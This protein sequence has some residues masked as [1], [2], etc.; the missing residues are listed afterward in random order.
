MRFSH[1]CAV[2]IHTDTH[3][4]GHTLV[5]V[6]H[7]F[8]LFPGVDPTRQVEELGATMGFTP[9]NG[10]LVNLSMGQG[11]E[12]PAEA[13]IARLADTGGWVVLQNL[14][15]MQTWL[16]TF[17]TMLEQVVQR[18][19]SSFRCFITAE[20]PPLAE[21]QT[22]PESLL[23]SCIKVRETQGGGTDCPEARERDVCMSV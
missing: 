5:R 19:H 15:L 20:A 17:T 22:L 21:M 18:A 1:V 8:V 23:Q 4:H 10:K 12:G 14:H 2:L 11:Q 9:L 13:A 6:V 16:P 3:S 7:R